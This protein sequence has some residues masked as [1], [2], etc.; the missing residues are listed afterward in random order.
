LRQLKTKNSSMVQGPSTVGTG[1]TVGQVYVH[2]IGSFA[3]AGNASLITISWPAA[4]MA[5][6][7]TSS[8]L[9]STN[10]TAYGGAVI[11]IAGTNLVTIA[12]RTGNLFFRL[13]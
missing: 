4:L 1:P 7:Q 5:T 3:I 11:N 2:D 13:H 6:L 9:A 12:P 10:W 8:S